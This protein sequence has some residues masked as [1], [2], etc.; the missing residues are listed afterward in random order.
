MNIRKLVAGKLHG[1]YVTEANLNY[2]HARPRSLRG[3][4]HPSH[5]VRILWNQQ[6]LGPLLDE[7]SGIGRQAGPLLA[8][9]Q[10]FECRKC[11]STSV[12]VGDDW[13]RI[14]RIRQPMAAEKV[15]RFRLRA[16]MD[17]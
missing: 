9:A 17:L 5:G 8:S 14:D 2:R 7:A 3:G 10:G 15:G 12:V 1:I 6:T 4:G 13:K 11:A 16:A